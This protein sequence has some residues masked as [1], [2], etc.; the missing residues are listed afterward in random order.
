[1]QTSIVKYK[2]A[3]L[4][5]HDHSDSCSLCKTRP[6]REHCGMLGHVIDRFWKKYPHLRKSFGDKH[7][8]LSALVADTKPVIQDNDDDNQYICLI[9]KVTHCLMG[10]LENANIPKGSK[11][12]SIDSGCSNHMT[13]DR[14][15]FSS[16]IALPPGESKWATKLPPKSVVRTRSLSS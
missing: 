7:K 3:A 2:A 9:G 15:Q 14:S 12:G 8:K 11:S 6:K 16:Y 5:V 13:Y 4:V 10:E 1:M